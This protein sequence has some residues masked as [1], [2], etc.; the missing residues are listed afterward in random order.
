MKAVHKEKQD[1]APVEDA[2]AGWKASGKLLEQA[3][4]NKKAIG[5]YEGVLKN[6]PHQAYLYDRLMIL[7]RKEKAYKKE[8]TLITKA[9]REFSALFQPGKKGHSKKIT[10]LSKSILRA[11]GLTDKKGAALYQPE[12]IARW[13]KRKKTLTQK[14]AAQ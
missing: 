13:E 10:S 6:Y 3:G 7:Y 1:A 2:G 14:M 11:V 5:L 8:L 4:D 12:P 9:V